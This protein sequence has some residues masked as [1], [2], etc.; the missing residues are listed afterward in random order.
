MATDIGGPAFLLI[1]VIF[2]VLL[3]AAMIYGTVW[4]RRRRQRPGI[5]RIEK[6]AVR[7]LYHKAPGEPTAASPEMPKND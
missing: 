3:A 6:E 1:D 5:E 7:D 2:V 4:W